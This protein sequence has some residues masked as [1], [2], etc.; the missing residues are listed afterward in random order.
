MNKQQIAAKNY[1]MRAYRIDNRINSKLDQ[2][3]SL[4]DL[5][6]RATSNISDMP[7]SPNR[8]IH[9]LED[10]IVKI[11]DLQNEISS[12]VNSLLEIKSQ[13]VDS[14]KMVNILCK[15]PGCA[16]LIPHGQM[17]CDEHKKVHVNND[18]AKTAE[19][20]YGGR[21]QRESKRFL[22]EHSLLE[23]WELAGIM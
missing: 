6:T 11:V 9:K 15:H 4:N 14:I 7:G 19:R 18:R 12:D 5:A 8:N 2:I 23:S 17:Y 3:A 16:T 21:W 20:G 1:L 22:R 13:I 10:A